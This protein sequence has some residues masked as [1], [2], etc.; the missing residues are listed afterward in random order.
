MGRA[1]FLGFGDFRRAAESYERA[2]AI[3]PQAGWYVLQLAH[4]YALLR[5][6]ERGHEA[7]LRAVSLQ[8]DFLSGRE[9]ILIVGAHMRLGHLAAL[10][11]RHEEAV[12]HFHS[13]IAFL[14]RV[15]HALR[16]RI[17]IE[18]RQRLGSAHLR[19]G[20]DAEGK[21]ELA[22]ALEGFEGRLRLG[23]DEPFSRYYAACAYAVRGDVDPALAYLERAI[24]MRRR[25][26]V[27]RARIEPEFDGLRGER[28]FRVL[29]G[30]SSP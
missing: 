2:I 3:N 16:N 19:L 15:D 17:L 24:R 20:R 1:F 18:L 13:E 10:Q 22:L 21:A 23:A 27:A 14:Q 5:D 9:G 7:A 4:C 8:E 26:T 25:F 28:R 6:F 12:E 29:V 30:E 11:G